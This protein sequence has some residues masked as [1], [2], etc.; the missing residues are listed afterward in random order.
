MASSSRSVRELA[1]EVGT[2]R[3]SAERETAIVGCI[4]GTAVADALGLACEGV[5]RQR[6]RKLFPDISRYHLVFGK[7]MTSDDTE[8]R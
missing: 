7:G 1:N 8:H 5:S 4:L 6:Q 3:E 2:M